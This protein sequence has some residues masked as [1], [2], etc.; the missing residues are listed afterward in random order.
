MV[1]VSLLRACSAWSPGDPR[2]SWEQLRAQAIRYE[3]I[4]SLLC[5]CWFVLSSGVSATV[6][7]QERGGFSGL[8]THWCSWSSFR[9]TRGTAE[10]WEERPDLLP[11]TGV[12][13]VFRESVQK[14]GTW[15]CSG[16]GTSVS[17]AVVFSSHK[18]SLEAEVNGEVITGCALAILYRGRTILLL[19]PFLWNRN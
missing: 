13:K 2:A 5:F 4:R 17:M 12:G 7:L 9:G 15:A 1:P 18:D 11:G 8:G 10:K 19:L 6:R 16:V 3:R 14:R